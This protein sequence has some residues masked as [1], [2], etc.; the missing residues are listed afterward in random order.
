MDLYWQRPERYYCYLLL[1][2]LSIII[3]NNKH[4]LRACHVSSEL[5]SSS[6]PSQYRLEFIPQPKEPELRDLQ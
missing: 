3:S 1:T 5:N 4:L 2:A 6:L